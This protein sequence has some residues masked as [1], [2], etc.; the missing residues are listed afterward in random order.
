MKISMKI[1][2]L[3][4]NYSVIL[5]RLGLMAYDKDLEGLEST[6]QTNFIEKAGRVLKTVG[7]VQPPTLPTTKSLHTLLPHECTTQSQQIVLPF[8]SRRN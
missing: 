3:E 6:L 7:G 8:Q 5:S 2:I 4:Y 1:S